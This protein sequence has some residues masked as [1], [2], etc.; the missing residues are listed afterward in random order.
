MNGFAGGTHR[1]PIRKPLE[2]GAYLIHSFDP[3]CITCAVRMSVDADGQQSVS[4]VYFMP[5]VF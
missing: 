2:G 3:L 1:L 4:V 5:C